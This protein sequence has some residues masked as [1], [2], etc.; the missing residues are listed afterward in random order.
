MN[1]YLVYLNTDLIIIY[2]F[3]IIKDINL[4]Y[5]W[6]LRLRLVIS[7]SSEYIQAE[8]A[9]MWLRM[10]GH[11]SLSIESVDSSI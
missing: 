8:D 6:L 11:L 1:G 5:K 10:E 4:L 3:R 2:Y 9:D 7:V